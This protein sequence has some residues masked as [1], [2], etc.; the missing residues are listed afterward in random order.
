VTAPT[1]A[2][3]MGELNTVDG[4]REL[5]AEVAMLLRSQAAAVFGNLIAVIPTMLLVAAAVWTFS[6]RLIMDHAHA[7]KILLDL[8]VIGPT[9]LYAA[10]TGILLWL[11]SLVAGVADNWFALRRL[12]ETLAHQ[13]RIVHALGAVRAE[14]WA[15][16]LE[17]HV[18]VIAG[19]VSLGIL[20]G[21]TPVR[22]A[23]FRFG[24]WIVRHVTLATGTLTAAAAS[25]GWDVL[26]QP[27]FW[28]AVVGVAVIGIL[29]VG[30][31][32]FPAA[33]GLALRG[34]G[35]AGA[36]PARGVSRRVAALQQFTVFVFV[37]G[38]AGGRGQQDDPGTI[39]RRRRTLMLLFRL[40]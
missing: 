13:R 21:M 5:L 8:Q 34:P 6:D 20:L 23:V 10:L 18:A 28:L 11:S 26:A 38:Q 19:N 27:G 12:R 33:R 1:P 4:L 14:R 9:P 31:A 17:R 30:V 22:G 35:R 37:P 32:T 40:A 2:S 15:A 36:Y 39:R 25:L 16:W 7:T 3:K 24:R 29:N